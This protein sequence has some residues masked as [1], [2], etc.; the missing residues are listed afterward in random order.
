MTQQAD[1]VMH[2]GI[3]V[4]E[5]AEVS[6]SMA[7]VGGRIMAIGAPELMPSREKRWT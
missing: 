3:I 2:G 7:I 4:N 5:N 1:L 6:A